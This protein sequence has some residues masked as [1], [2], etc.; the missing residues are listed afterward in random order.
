MAEVKP[1][2]TA[3]RAPALRKVR[4]VVFMVRLHFLNMAT[5]CTRKKLSHR[6]LFGTSGFFEPRRD[7]FTYCTAIFAPALARSRC[8]GLLTGTGV[9]PVRTRE[10]ARL[11][12]PALETQT[13]A[14]LKWVVDHIGRALC[15]QQ[16]FAEHT[17][18]DRNGSTSC[19]VAGGDVKGTVAY[20]DAFLW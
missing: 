8:R 14:Y 17:P 12:W 15:E 6:P 1:Q 18:C 2:P 10:A 3:A 7:I 20:I 4:R 11:R 16:I 9:I 13:P 19:G 5:S